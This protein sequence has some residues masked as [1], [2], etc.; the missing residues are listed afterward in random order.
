MIGG[1]EHLSCE[2][3]LRELGLLSLEKAVGRPPFSTLQPFQYVEGACKKD[4][5]K[6]FMRG[7]C[8]RARGNGFELKEGRFRLDIRKTSFTM[9]VVKWWN[10]LAHPWKHSR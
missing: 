7:C 10:R 3:R 6:L 9:R 8:H 4:G 5:D 2:E 1:L